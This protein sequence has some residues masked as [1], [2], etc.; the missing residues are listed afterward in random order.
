MCVINIDP[1]VIIIRK[2]FIFLICDD[3]EGKESERCLLQ[4]VAM[5][6]LKLAII[7]RQPL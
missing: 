7:I 3:N 2:I 4:R 1:V 6:Q 5:G